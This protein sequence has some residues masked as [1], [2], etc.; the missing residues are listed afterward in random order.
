MLSPVGYELGSVGYRQDVGTDDV[1]G[2]V[3]LT[4]GD[5]IIVLMDLDVKVETEETDVVHLESG[6]HLC[7]ESLHLCFFH[8]GD[9][10]VIDI[11]AHQQ[12][13]VSSVSP[14]HRCLVHALL[15]AH[16]LEPAI[17][18]GVPGSQHLAFLTGNDEAGTLP[19]IHLLLQVA[20]E[21][22]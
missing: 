19:N 13:R 15:E 11:D 8:A 18:L 1:L 3:S 9:D 6:L 4:E 22:R 2:V 7:L 20:V 16:L 14:V 12:N 5:A 17:Q 21:E 10:E